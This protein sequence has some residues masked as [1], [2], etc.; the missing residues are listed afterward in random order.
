M[1]KANENPI[2]GNDKQYSS[3]ML[4][5]IPQLV[6]R[7]ALPTVLTMLITVIYNTADTYFVS[8]IDKSASAA[9]GAVYAVM[10]IIQ[11]VGYGCGMGAGSLISRK[12][13][14]QDMESSERYAVSA[15]FAALSLGTVIG[16]AGLLFINPLMQAIGCSDTMLPHAIPY[17]RYILAAAPL[18]CSSFVL[19]NVLRAEGHTNLSMW[20]TMAGGILNLILDPLFIFTCKMGTGGAALATAVS[21]CV[22]FFILLLYFLLGK[23][24]VRLRL[25][26]IS[27]SPRDYGLIIATGFPTV[28][29]QG[30]G[31]IAA[32]CLTHQALLYG[33]DAGVSAINIANKAYV[34]VRN[35][36][37][38]IGQGFQPVAG[39][40]FG[41]GNR[42]RTK[43][44]FAFATIM[45]TG[46]CILSAI[47]ISLFAGHI[48]FWF[49]QDDEVVEIGR[50]TMLWGCAVMPFLAFSTFV[51]QLHQCLGFKISATFLAS[52]RQGI[53]YLPAIFL[54]P[55][56]LGLTG[57]ELAQ[58]VADLMTAGI[59]VPFLAVFMR[60]QLSDSDSH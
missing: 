1:H 60:R 40:N 52:C 23:T 37:I 47:L 55:L 15:F 57:V 30:L 33:G 32:V 46:V 39:Y 44:A 50:R 18:S 26:H 7:L 43:Q 38:G 6:A 4:E 2:K 58:P 45:G 13:G 16:G 24:T 11:T 21:Q 25:S 56:V 22:S 28:C 3:M 49:I 14:A 31:S 20:G 5:P 12:L 36:I 48:M 19:S 8:Q 10:A 17:A 35:V 34:L 54:L 27:R 9:V 59:S 53:F 41:A 42:R 51:N 29:R